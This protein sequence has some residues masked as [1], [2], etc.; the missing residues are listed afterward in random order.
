MPTLVVPSLSGMNQ[1]QP[2]SNQN[3]V[4][5]PAALPGKRFAPVKCP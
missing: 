4:M 3:T 5:L 1:N 2:W